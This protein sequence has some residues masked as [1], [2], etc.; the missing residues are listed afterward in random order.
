MRLDGFISKVYKSR[1]NECMV[2]DLNKPQNYNA[3][4]S[5]HYYIDN[6]RV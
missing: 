2:E 6:K 1:S 5:L 4:V 3:N